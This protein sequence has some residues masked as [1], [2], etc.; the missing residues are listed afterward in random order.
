[1]TTPLFSVIIPAYN[2]ASTLGAA[3]QS[4]LDQTC[5]DFEIVIVD[6]GSQDDPRS[7]AEAFADP[8]IRFF[9]KENEGGGV[10]RNTAIEMAVGRY[11]AP[12]DSDDIF[13]PHHLEAMKT[14]LKGTTNVAGY[15]RVIVDRGDGRTFIKPPHGIRPGQ[16]MGEYLLCERGFVP[17]ITI[18]VEREMAL[19]V[20]YHV[21][22]RPAEDTD[23][24]M[25]LALSGCTFRMAEQPG[26]IWNDI[27][28]PKRTSASAGTLRFATWLKQMR[29]LMTQRAWYGA[30][31][32]AFAK[33]V[34]RERGRRPALRLYLR[35][36]L[37]GCYSPRLAVVV[38]LQVL[39]TPQQYRSM[40]DNAIRW[41]H[42]GLREEDV[43]QGEPVRKL[44]TT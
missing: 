3:I 12:L 23:F 24:A 8:R 21:N 1:M 43:A 31:G 19:K 18:V 28:D 40:A 2:R 15:A 22:L 35:A 37:H 17:T 7:V 10:A 27:S 4:V 13:L 29:P 38:F 5:Q 14:M 26:A 42:A 41:L 32:W 25:R 34:M 20:R 39:L 36:L 6:D 9:A 44:E 30:Q 16:D 11:I 33:L